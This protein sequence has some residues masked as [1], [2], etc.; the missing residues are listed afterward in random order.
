MIHKT[1]NPFLLLGYENP[2]Y[3]CDRKT[4]TGKIIDALKNGRNN[5][6]NNI[7]ELFLLFAANYLLRKI[8]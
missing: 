1:N 4:E 5:L 7:F 2:K 6:N 3:F 8:S